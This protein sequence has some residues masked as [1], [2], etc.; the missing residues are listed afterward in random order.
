[1]T[2][3]SVPRLKDLAIR[4]GWT[5]AQAG[6][7]FAITEAGNLP[8]EYAVPI[9]GLLSVA[10]SFIAQRLEERKARRPKAS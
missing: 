4:A 7:G 10:K 8:T 3:F 2:F 1:V 9:A 6:V 5:L